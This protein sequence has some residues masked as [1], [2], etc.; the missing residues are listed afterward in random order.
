MWKK[1]DSCRV[2]LKKDGDVFMVTGRHNH[3]NEEQEIAAIAFE[4]ECKRQAAQEPGR[5]KRIFERV[6]R[7]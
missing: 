7:E 3:E 6:R 5:P 2:Q 1:D 4:S